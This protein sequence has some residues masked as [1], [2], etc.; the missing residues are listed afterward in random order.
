MKDLKDIGFYTLSDERAKSASWNS[1]LSRCE[2]ILTDRCNFKCPYCRGL[3]PSLRGDI[4]SPFA[5]Y[6]IK[7]W[8]EHGLKNIRFSGGE[9]TL[10]PYL[11]DFISYARRNFVERIAIS[12]NGSNNLIYYISLIDDGVN[13]FSFSL[14]S[15]CSD[16]GRKMSGGV[17]GAW[18][19]VVRNIELVAKKVYT[20]VG[21]VL[22]KDNQEEAERTI[23]LADSLGVSDIRVIPSAQSS[24]KLEIDIP[25]K[26]LKKYPILKY[27]YENMKKGKKI[28]GMTEKDSPICR[29][30]LDD[31]AVVKGKHYPCI[32]YLRENGDPIGK[33]SEKMREERKQWVETHNC[34]EDRICRNNCLDVCV[35]YNNTAAGFAIMNSDP[36]SKLA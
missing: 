19:K 8:A 13:D 31:M 6:T 27:R 14:D 30:A 23:L 26:L 36:R 16:G 29:L 25:E 1:P 34:F 15:C 17:E 21:I 12:T 24:D 35:E 5:F 10:H 22:T 2:L 33:V 3:A 32:I 9:P 20:T 7:L 4:F 11:R 18:E 28:R